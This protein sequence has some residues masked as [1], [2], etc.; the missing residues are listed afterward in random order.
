MQ[1]LAVPMHPDL[2]SFVK[3]PTAS[4]EEEL[5]QTAGRKLQQQQGDLFQENGGALDGRRSSSPVAYLQFNQR[6]QCICIISAC[7]R[8]RKVRLRL[9]CCKVSSPAVQDSAQL[10]W[11]RAAQ[12]PMHRKLNALSLHHALSHSGS[13]QQCRPRL[14]HPTAAAAAAAQHAAAHLP[15]TPHHSTLPATCVSKHPGHFTVD[16]LRLLQHVPLRVALAS[17]CRVHILTHMH[18]TTVLTL[19]FACHTQAPSLANNEA[20]TSRMPDRHAP[21]HCTDP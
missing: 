21:H 18:P 4:L 12:T 15:N 7:A 1:A 11:W 19:P 16:V 13:K 14:L 5:Q 2:L 3:L 6:I 17:P 9:E 8:G 10:Q 20:L